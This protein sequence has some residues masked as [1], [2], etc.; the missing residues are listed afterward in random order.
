MTLS[1]FLEEDAN[2]APPKAPVVMPEPPK[3]AKVKSAIPPK[4]DYAAMAAQGS[5]LG[6][7]RESIRRDADPDEDEM[8]AAMEEDEIDRR[9][10]RDENENE[11]DRRADR[12]EN[13]NEDD[14]EAAEARA[15]SAAR[16]RREAAAAKRRRREEENRSRG[17]VLRGERIGRRRR[18]LLLRLRRIGRGGGDRDDDETETRGGDETG[19][20]GE[21]ADDAEEGG[22]EP[23]RAGFRSTAGGETDD[24]SRTR[25]G[26]KCGRRG[27]G[28]GGEVDA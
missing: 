3:V 20:E 17:E 27:G 7:V 16:R 15:A 14:F 24:R 18:G 11:I 1:S 26:E 8:L 28:G 13:E 2:R 5:G 4:P 23:T 6:G 25:G 19:G 9:A 22:R 21:G 12:D 10:D